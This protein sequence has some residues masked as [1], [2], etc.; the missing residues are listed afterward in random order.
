MNDIIIRVTVRR[1]VELFVITVVLSV[2]LTFLNVGHI[3]ADKR[4]L[5]VGMLC[6]I[7]LFAFVNFKMLRKCYFD[8]ADNSMYFKSN[9]LAYLLF[10]GVGYLI[11]F[12]CPGAV[13]TWLFAV[14]KF[15][16]YASGEL[17]VPYSAALFHCVGLAII[18][19]APIGMKW[20]FMI[21]NND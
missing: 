9:I 5:S 10:A 18:F 19:A 11:Y 21:K 12:T 7:A 20:V 14:E 6:A 13:Y 2:I 16:R 15:A 1:F 8:L 3:L 17:A 4:L